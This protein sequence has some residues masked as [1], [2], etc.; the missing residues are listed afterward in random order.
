MGRELLEFL[1]NG[2]VFVDAGEL[3]ASLQALNASDT[4][5]FTFENAMDVAALIAPH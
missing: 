5:E 2:G 4:T 1:D 3:A